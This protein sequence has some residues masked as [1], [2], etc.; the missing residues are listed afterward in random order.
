MSAPHHEA[1]VSPVG[2]GETPHGGSPRNEA[3]SAP[4]ASLPPAA[5]AWRGPGTHRPRRRCCGSWSPP[6]DQNTYDK[7]ASLAH[8]RDFQPHEQ[9]EV[10]V[11]DCQVIILII[12]SPH[13]RHEQSPLA[14]VQACV[15]TFGNKTLFLPYTSTRNVYIHSLRS[16]DTTVANDL[17]TDLQQEVSHCL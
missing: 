6:S 9:R 3:G 5:P 8:A 7:A 14:G 15:A 11:Y 13:P 10:L 16:T 2:A 4:G 1:T 17:S 12:I